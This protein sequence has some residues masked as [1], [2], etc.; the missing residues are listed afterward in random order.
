VCQNLNYGNGKLRNA[1]ISSLYH[2]VF[3]NHTDTRDIELIAK[4]KGIRLPVLRKILT[5]VGKNQYG[6]YY[7]M[8]LHKVLPTHVYVPVYYPKITPLYTM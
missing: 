2:L 1:R 4:N 6:F 5:D 8:V 3:N 7:L